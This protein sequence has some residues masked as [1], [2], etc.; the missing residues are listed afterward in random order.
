MTR[1]P[2]SLSLKW[3]NPRLAIF[4]ANLIGA[5]MGLR[6]TWNGVPASQAGVPINAA[7]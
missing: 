6:N 7:I 5:G 3:Q 4:G 2:Q 1:L